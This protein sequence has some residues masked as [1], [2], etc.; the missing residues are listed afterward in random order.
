MPTK[1]QIE[2]A[3]CTRINAFLQRRTGRG[4]GAIT[5]ALHPA[6]L[7]VH[8]KGALTVTETNL[9]AVG[10]RDGH[11]STSLVRAWREQII[12]TGQPELVGE[13]EELLGKKPS[14]LLHDVDP[15]SGEEVLVFSFDPG[16][17]TDGARRPANATASPDPT[18]SPT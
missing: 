6:F 7:V 17:R 2:A 16:P 1:G 14:S 4:A 8:L 3:A 11:D 18:R 15:E 5:A 10:K 13:C 12:R 9:I